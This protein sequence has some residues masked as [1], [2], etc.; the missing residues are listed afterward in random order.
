PYTDYILDIES[1]EIGAA[2]TAVGERV[3]RRSFSTGAFVSLESFVEDFVGTQTEHRAVEPGV[4]QAIAADP[5]F[6]SRDPEGAEFDEALIDAGLEP[7]PVPGSPRVVVFWQQANPGDTPQPAAVLVDASEPMHRTRALPEEVTSDDPQPVTRWALTEQTWLTL[8][9]GASG[10]GIVDR[11]LFAP[12]RQRAL[13]T[14]ADGARG[15]VLHLELVRQVFDAPF[16]DGPGA[17]PSRYRIVSDTLMRAPWE[18]E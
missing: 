1:V 3:L 13:V 11:V 16:L 18:E 9:E 6:A 17:T 8:E 5:R 15:S 2:P 14:F 7:M 12:G 4:L 10:D